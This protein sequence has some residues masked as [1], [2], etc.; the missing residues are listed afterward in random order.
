M[1]HLEAIRKTIMNFGANVIER[2]NSVQK[3]SGSQGNTVAQQATAPMQAS[4]QTSFVV[5]G[6]TWQT[7][8]DG[9]E[10]HRRFY[11]GH[12]LTAAFDSGVFSK[13]IADGSFRDIFPGDY[14]VREVTILDNVYPSVGEHFENK[15]YT[16]KFIITDLDYALNRE[17]FGVRSHHSVIVPEV[18]PFQAC[19]NTKTKHR[20]FLGFN[21]ANGTIFEKLCAAG[22][23]SGS[24]MQKTVIPV[25]T[26][27][28]TRAFGAAHI[29]CFNTDGQSRRCRIMTL[30]MVFGK[31]L[32]SSGY[33]YSQYQGVDKSM[34][35]EQLAAFYLNPDLKFK[36]SSYWLSDVYSASQFAY[37]EYDSNDGVFAGASDAWNMI[38]VRPFALL[39]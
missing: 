21:D 30:H 18:S 25:F 4:N 14:I 35:K 16:V 7:A 31:T 33:S 13:N 12:D 32:P 15:T 17:G 20:L 37:V 1:K 10:S 38:G 23:Y 8:S 2:N 6:D 5:S 24:S 11:R 27:M 19:M 34:G 26:K 3:N 28:L 39:R 9:A 36:E 29:L 22:G